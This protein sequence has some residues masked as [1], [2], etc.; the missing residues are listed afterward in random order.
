MRRK[1]L[2]EYDVVRVDVG[3]HDKNLDLATS[4]GVDL[5]ASGIPFLAV[6]AADGPP[7]PQARVLANQ[8]TGSLESG[9][10]HDPKKV[11]EFLTKHQAEYLMAEDLYRSGLKSA[12]EQKKRVFL[13]FGAP[14]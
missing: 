7:G 1:L 5:K 14:W 3:R 9:E 2:Y 10:K 12:E 13:I 4:F 6:L 11:L 8:E